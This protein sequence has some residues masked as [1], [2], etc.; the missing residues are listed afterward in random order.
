MDLWR[1]ILLLLVAITLFALLAYDTRG[2]LHHAWRLALL[3]SFAILGGL[4]WFFTEALGTFRAI[5]FGGLAASW[6]IAYAAAL[7]IAVVLSRHSLRSS[8]VAESANFTRRVRSLSAG[9]SAALLFMLLASAA[10]GVI[11]FTAA[12]NTWDSLTYHLSRIMHWQQDRSLAFYAT[13]IQRQLSFGPLAEMAMLQFQVL[14][15]TDRLVNFVQFASMLGCAIGGS[16]IAER[17]GGDVRAQTLSALAS[18][19]LPMGVLQATST[20]N[21]YVV[22]LWCLSFVAFTLVPPDQADTRCHALMS[23]ATLGLAV[24]TKATA[25]LFLAPMGIWYAVRVFRRFG[26]G[27][28]RPLATVCIVALMI[29]APHSLRNWDLYGN[30]LGIT[31]G[32]EPGSYTNRSFGLSTLGSNLLRNIGLQLTSPVERL[33]QAVEQGIVQ[34]HALVGIDPNAPATTWEGM[35]FQL[36]FSMYEDNA[37]NL[38]HFLLLLAAGILLMRLRLPAAKLYMGCIGVAFLLFCLVLKWQPWNSRLVLPLFVL[39]MPALGVALSGHL[40]GSRVYL[41]GLVLA[42]AALPYLLF[43]PTRP[44]IGEDSIFLKDRMLQYFR[45]V[46]DS[47]PA[48]QTGARVISSLNCGRVGLVSP[49]DGREYLLWVTNRAYNPNIQIEHVMVKNVSRRYEKSFSPCAIV[50]TL[51]IAESTLVYGGASYERVVETERFSVFVS[52]SGSP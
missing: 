4:V 31:S 46:P 16:L 36:V 37:G 42:L 29:L 18:M 9:E 13:A 6:G 45:N 3:D 11:A 52:G 39:A 25:L 17:L 40:R 33:N 7:I 50:V 22:A 26:P 19:T 2:L 10:L 41:P 44:M 49:T 20:Q 24:L 15:G 12:P 21:D 28:W 35:R 47:F 38:L 51:P 34:A 43:N 8:I 30:P 14:S 48:Y 32:R 5:T 23:G 1:S 27:A